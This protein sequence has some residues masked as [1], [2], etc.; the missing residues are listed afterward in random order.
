[1]TIEYAVELKLIDA[2]IYKKLLMKGDTHIEFTVQE[3]EDA[4]SRKDNGLRTLP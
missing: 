2:Q 1:M 3:R 4:E